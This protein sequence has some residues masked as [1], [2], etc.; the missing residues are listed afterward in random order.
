MRQPIREEVIDAI[1]KGI[2]KSQADYEVAYYSDISS[3]YAPEYLMTVYI[4]QSILELKVK[5]DWPYTLS[6][7]EPV[8]SLVKSLGAHGRPQNRLRVRGKCDLSLRDDN[9]RA[10]AVAVIEVKKDAWKYEKDLGRIT[11]L[12]EQGLEFGIFASCRF[13]EVKDGNAKEAKDRLKSEIQCIYEHMQRAIKELG[14]NL[15]VERVLGT[16]TDWPSEGKPPDPGGKWKW[17]PVCF[18]IC[19]KKKH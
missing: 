11:C 10:R 17:C 8:R 14:Y 12:V 13:E 1:I 16:I 9:D 4:F 6:L 19:D 15:Y 3:P 7:E 2:N 5:Y 18:V